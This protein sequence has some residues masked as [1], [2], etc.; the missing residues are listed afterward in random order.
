MH[1]SWRSKWVW[2][3]RMLFALIIGFGVYATL[4]GEVGLDWWVE[5]GVALVSCVVIYFAM[6]GFSYRYSI[7]FPEYWKDESKD[8]WKARKKVWNAEFEQRMKERGLRYESWLKMMLGVE[9]EE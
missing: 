9:E 4:E 8:E 5:W 7:P 6:I 1:E 2:P 3:W